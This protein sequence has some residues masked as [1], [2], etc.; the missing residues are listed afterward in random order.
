[1]AIDKQGSCMKR[2]QS[3]TIWLLPL[4]LIGGLFSPLF[5]Y[6]VLAMMVFLLSLSFFK[7]R[8]W[9]WNFCPRGAFLDIVMS[10]VSRNT[11]FP[12]SLMHQRIRWLIFSLFMVFL[13]FRLIKAGSSLAAIGAVFVS[14][15]IITTLVA[16][17]I[18][19]VSKHRGWC[20][21]C[22]MGTLQDALHKTNPSQ[23]KTPK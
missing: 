22:P 5:G 21:I 8:Y 4:I 10:K 2:T 17:I 16:I 1:M 18:G 19:V 13:V 12:K 11:P 7:G 14:M 20:I 3:V 9:C 15:C 6:S 23:R